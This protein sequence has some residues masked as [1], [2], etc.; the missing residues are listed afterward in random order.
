[1]GIKIWNTDISK[2]YVYVYETVHVTW[3]SLDKYSITLTTIWQTEQLTATITPSNADDQTVTWSSSDTT[4]ATVS[5]TGLVTCITPWTAI[6]TVTTNDGWY[7][8]FCNVT[9]WL[10]AEYQEVEYI[11]SSGSQWI[12][13]WVTPK[14]N[15]KSQIKFINLATTG[16]VIYGMY[17]WSDSNDYRLFNAS[18]TMY[19]DFNSD[20]ISWASLSRDVLYELELGNFYVKNVWAS[21][22]IL[23]WNPISS[24]TWGRTITLNNYNNSSYSSNKWYYVKIWEWAT[25]VRDFI[26]CYRKLDTE[27][28]MYDLINNQFYTNAWS[29][30]F[31]KWAD[32]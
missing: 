24:Y 32:V 2:M 6:I 16:N 15:T 27:I 22:N 19:F 3:V 7:T 5:T 29:W 17:N 21:S 11:Q 23:S 4:V 8:A 26:P 18:W 12:D 1:M 30:T 13:T 28:W 20:R 9:Q 31:S 14:D 25:Q 10:P